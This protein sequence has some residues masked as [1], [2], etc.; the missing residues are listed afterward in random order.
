MTEY[1]QHMDYC[2]KIATILHMAFWNTFSWMQTSIFIFI[3]ISLRFV[4]NGSFDNDNESTWVQIMAWHRTGD[5]P[6]SEPK[7]VWFSDIYLCCLAYVSQPKMYL[8]LREYLD[9][10][11]RQSTALTH[12]HLRR[13]AHPAW[14]MDT[15]PTDPCGMP[16]RGILCGPLPRPPGLWPSVARGYL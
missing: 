9:G 7:V 16:L 13:E 1:I 14:Y 3:E 12:L 15:D 4:A 5:K 8:L 10:W 2:G 11:Q 6:L